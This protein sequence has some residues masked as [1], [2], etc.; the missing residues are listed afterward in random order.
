MP[1]VHGQQHLLSQQYSPLTAG[2]LMKSLP[3]SLIL[4]GLLLAGVGCQVKNDPTP[5]GGQ[6]ALPDGITLVES[7][8]RET[9]DQLIIPYKKYSLDNG[10]TVILH[11]DNSDPL[12]HV[13]V[14]YHVGSGREEVGKSGFAHFFEHLLFEGTKNIKKGEWF[15]I[16]TGNGGSNNAYTT[17]DFTYYYENFP[18]NNLELG[19]WMESERMLNAVISQAGVDNQREVVK[20]ELRERNENTPY[21]SIMNEVFEHAFESHPYRWTPGGSPEY[22]NQANLSEF[23]EFYKTFYVPNNACISIAGDISLSQSKEWIEKYF[24][25]KLKKR[26]ILTHRKDLLMG[27]YLI[28]DRTKNGADNFEGEHIHFG[29]E[30][31]LRWDDV[32]SYLIE[33]TTATE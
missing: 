26:L 6:P 12:V 9:P 20:E 24:G 33:K 22:I 10:L 25:D 2:N 32:T 17:N 7:V 28:D 18:S 14:T 27:D 13:D 15:K 31:F 29:T 1:E 19:L 5:I 4:L 23:M 21:G 11:E 8:E 3:L 30:K 16:V